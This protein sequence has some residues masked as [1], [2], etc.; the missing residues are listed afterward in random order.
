MNYENYM[1]DEM[2]EDVLRYLVDNS[3]PDCF[4]MS[5]GKGQYER[6]KRALGE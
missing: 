1:D 5:F 3:F 4:D 2:A 6:A